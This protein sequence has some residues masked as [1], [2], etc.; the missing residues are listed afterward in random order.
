MTHV[1]IPLYAGVTPLDFAGPYQLLRALPEMD[2]ELAAIDRKEVAADIGA[3][4]AG[5]LA[6][7]RPDIGIIR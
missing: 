5:R 4:A 3:A 1:V 6:Q 7:H 2:I